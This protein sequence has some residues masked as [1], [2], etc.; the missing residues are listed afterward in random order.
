M[1]DFNLGVAGCAQNDEIILK[2]AT[3][4]FWY[5]VF[6]TLLE[7]ANFILFSMKVKRF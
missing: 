4:L 2:L 3:T 5:F 7:T 1:I 6:P